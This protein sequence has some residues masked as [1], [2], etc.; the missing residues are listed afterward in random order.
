MLR[1]SVIDAGLSCIWKFPGLRDPKR[2]GL[3][4]YRQLRTKSPM[5]G[6]T[7]QWSTSPFSP[8]N[9][10]GKHQDEHRRRTACPTISLVHH[11]KK[12]YQQ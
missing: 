9:W 3:A 12:R 1:A 8:Y 2:L 7:V 11:Q 10:Q 5:P 6:V 4:D